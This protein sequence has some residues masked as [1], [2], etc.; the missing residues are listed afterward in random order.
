[1]V[2]AVIRRN[3]A[4]EFAAV[5]FTRFLPRQLTGKLRSYTLFP[6]PI[7]Y[8]ILIIQTRYQPWFDWRNFQGQEYK[9]A[10]PSQTLYLESALEKQ[11]AK[12]E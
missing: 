4:A 3:S 1:M 5:N 12:L 11:K 8:F 7:S 9:L 2:A 6:M 10:Y